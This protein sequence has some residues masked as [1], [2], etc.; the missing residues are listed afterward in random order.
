MGR[1][2]LE[3]AEALMESM[4]SELKMATEVSEPSV[5]L[6]LEWCYLCV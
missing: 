3:Q 5:G 6:R 4:Q 1:E 2:K